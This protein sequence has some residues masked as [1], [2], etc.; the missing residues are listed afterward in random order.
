MLR[1]YQSQAINERHGNIR[2]FHLLPIPSLF[3]EFPP[4]VDLT[5]CL[6]LGRVCKPFLSRSLFLKVPFDERDFDLSG[7]ITLFEAMQST[8]LFFL[9]PCAHTHTCTSDA[10]RTFFCYSCVN[11]EIV[12]ICGGSVWL[13]FHILGEPLS[14]GYMQNGFQLKWA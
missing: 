11:F 14:N 6:D 10:V 9:F 4:Y 8:T 7:E 2:V 12:T 5:I 13:H 1:G 3:L